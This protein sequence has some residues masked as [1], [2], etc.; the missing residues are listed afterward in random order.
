MRIRTSVVANVVKTAL[1]AR[2]ERP[3]EVDSVVIV[4]C[5]IQDTE[6]SVCAAKEHRS[7]GL[8]KRVEVP[9]EDKIKIEPG[10]PSFNT[11][12]CGTEKNRESLSRPSRRNRKRKGGGSVACDDA[13]ERSK[14][15]VWVSLCKV[16]SSHRG[17]RGYKLRNKDRTI[18]ISGDI[19]T[20]SML[21]VVVSEPISVGAPFQPRKV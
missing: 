12:L 14:R 8:D 3:L 15:T 13:Q 7:S 19:I 11:P 1:T 2:A 5:I 9:V 6:L 16:P 21:G 18:G 20:N 10:P 17:A 4:A